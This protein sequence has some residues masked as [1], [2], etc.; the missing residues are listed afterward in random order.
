MITKIPENGWIKYMNPANNE[1]LPLGH[2][3]GKSV[4]IE[5]ICIRNYLIVSPDL[6][7]NTCR[8]GEW[9]NPVPSCQP[10]CSTKTIPGPLC[11][12]MSQPDQEPQFR[13]PARIGTKHRSVKYSYSL[14]WKTDSGR[15]H[16]NSVRQYVEK[17]LQLEH[18]ML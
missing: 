3:I 12:A 14:V 8:N 13:S 6:G 18:H 16:H 4:K 5:Y 2:N 10:R 11:V 17:R 1:T 15:H 9:Q 7:T